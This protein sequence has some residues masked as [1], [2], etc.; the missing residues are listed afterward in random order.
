MKRKQLLSGI[1]GILLVFGVLV[2]T[3]CPNIN[4]VNVDNEN[5]NSTTISVVGATAQSS[6][7]IR[8]SWDAVSGATSYKVY[9]ST[10]ADGPYIQVGST[11]TTLSYTDTG[12]SQSTTYYYK[13]SAV[14]SAG[15]SEQSSFV[16]ETTS[17]YGVPSGISAAAQSS[18]SIRIS[19]NAVSGATSY[20][21]YRS[22]SESGTYIRVGSSST[23]TTPSYTDTG[24]SSNTTYYYKV[25]AVTGARESEQSSSVSVTTSVYGVPSVP[26]GVT[27]AAQ[28]SSSILISWNAVSGAASYRVYRS[29]SESGTYQVGSS[30]TITTPSYTDTGLSAG[31]TYYYKVSAVNSAGE[32]E[33]SSYTSAT[34]TSDA[35]SGGGTTQQEGVY[36]GIISF[37]G[38]ANDLTGGG[39]VFLDAAGKTS[40]LSKLNADYTIASQ[41]G[42]ALFYSVH[43][44]LANLKS[45]D[46][47]YPANLDSVNLITFT[48]GLDNGSTGMSAVAPIEGRIFTSDTEYT[49]YLSREIASRTI[50]GKPIT[51]YSVGV[52]GSDVSDTAKFQNDLANIASPGKSQSLTDFGS[53]QTTFQNIADSLQI[54]HRSTTFTMKTTLLPS[55]TKVRMTFDVTGTNP[56]AS[57]KYIEGT[58]TAT[59]TGNNPTYT[60]G[61]ITYAGGLSSAQGAGPITGSRNSSEVNF[62]FTSVTNYDPSTDKSKAKQWIM[63]PD[64]SAWQVNSEYD[65]G[66]ETDTQIEKRSSIIYLVLDSSRSLSTAQIGQIRSAAADFINSLYNQLNGGNTGNGTTTAPSAPTGVTASAA[67]SSSITVSWNSVSGASSYRVY[68][69]TSSS[70]TYSQV[71]S[72]SATSYTDTGLPLGTTYYYKVSAYN[73]Y[74]ESSKSSYAYATTNSS[75]SGSAGSASSN[76][77]TLSSSTQLSGTVSSSSPAVWYRI[78]VPSSSGYYLSGLDRAYSS[79]Y[80]SNVSFEIYNSGLT[81]IATLDGNTASSHPFSSSGTY[82]IK[83]VPYNE[84]TSNYGTYF[85]SF[86]Y[87]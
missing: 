63:G 87:K 10:S 70:G 33:Q 15:E 48:D 13:I 36:I 28:S 12:L 41:G 86:L 80:T 11:I 9:R 42:T 22:A 62:T 79:S 2:C 25:S 82:Y 59:V 66:G 45:R 4:T 37:A 77:I 29:A 50:G 40:L 54:T 6:S 39:P 20:R 14:T 83:V 32:S 23:I 31:T 61:N 19:W 65:V 68:R 84:Y 7:S 81:L 73:S 56:S 52:M 67:S 44:A 49:A 76:P 47:Q 46:A 16:S 57:S 17:A 55:G 71:T 75:S 78:S 8:I 53:L 30:S 3:A 24:L 21:V 64:S 74:V 69:S 18:S 60:F 26:S 51:A 1:L 34:T 72:T 58:I 5:N 27:A 43:R 85:I 38:T 35:S